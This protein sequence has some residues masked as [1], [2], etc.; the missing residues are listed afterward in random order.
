MTAVTPENKQEQKIEQPET[1]VHQAI[2]KNDKPSGDENLKM[3]EENKPNFKA[4]REQRE[5]D[6]KA[7][8]AAEK[9]A[10]EKTAEAEALKAALEASLNR[11]SNNRQMNDSDS[12]DIEETEEQ[13]I[14]R[15]VALAIKQREEQY[16]KDRMEREKNEAPV[17][18]LQTYPDFKQVVT[19]ENC[20]YLDFHH[21][22]LT[23]PFKYMP[24]GYDKWSAM[25]KAIKKLVPNFDSR[26]DQA[27]A[28][29]NLMK[30]GSVSS[31]GTT[32]P[33][34]SAPFPHLTEERKKANW[35]RMQRD[36][37]GVK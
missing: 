19:V 37:K 21:P 20:D 17:R 7:K 10:A 23:E 3:S 26:K 11:P 14:D 18:I 9:R 16:E 4:F 30:P 8:E 13:R 36:R 33:T 2:D 6:R 35:E 28:E 32:Q 12:A 5:A 22:E 34:P 25:Y 27:R 24:D 31:T 29:K 1:V 15:R